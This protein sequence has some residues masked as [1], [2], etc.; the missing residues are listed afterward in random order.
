MTGGAGDF[1]TSVDAALRMARA[2]LGGDRESAALDSAILLAWVLQRER[3]WLIAHGDATLAPGHA[4]EFEALIEQRVRGEPIAYLTGRRGFWSLDLMVA[5]GVL[6]PRPET[7]QLVQRALEILPAKTTLD[8]LDLGTGSGAIALA[9]AVER[10]AARVLGVD[11]SMDA[12][13]IASSNAQRLDLCNL[14]FLRSDWLQSV[15]AG[16]RF[17]L[18]VSNPPYVAS[19]DPHLLRGDLRFEPPAALVS[20]VDGLDA[21][22]KIVSGARAH[23]RAGAAL[24]VEH[25]STQG[26]GVRAEFMAAGFGCVETLQDLAGHDRITQGISAD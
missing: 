10:P 12:L 22:R 19:G 21:I 24:V 26:A 2:R 16:T 5:P 7:E 14:A 20:G 23:L 25:G 8:V 3:T 6:I 17:D 13:R 9:I 15:R 18:I 1:Q 4:S 11:R